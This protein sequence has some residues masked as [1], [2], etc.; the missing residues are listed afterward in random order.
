MAKREQSQDNAP[1]Q[2]LEQ[3]AYHAYRE[4][5]VWLVL[6]ERDLAQRIDAAERPP[7]SSTNDEPEK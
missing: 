1:W 5:P 3:G 2:A 6:R 7:D 4:W